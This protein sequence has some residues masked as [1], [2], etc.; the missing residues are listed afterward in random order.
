MEQENE[1]RELIKQLQS[2]L[3]SSEHKQAQFESQLTLINEKL[4]KCP[5]EADTAEPE[6]EIK[7]R[8]DTGDQIL[9]DSYKCIPEFSGN[10]GQ[11]RSWRN[12]VIRRMRMI[13]NF[14]NHPKYEA[15]LG[16][17]RAKITGPASDVLTN[18]K[19]AYNIDSIIKRLD[20]SYADQRPL[21]IVEAE[22]TS[23]KQSN[24][25][26][27]EFHDAINQAL[28]MVIT[29][30]TID[31]SDPHE[32]RALVSEAQQKAIRTFT[33]GLKSQT[34]RNILYNHKPATLAEAF[35]TAQ[36]AYYDNQY[37]Q[38][39][40]N[41]EN[42]RNP[43][44][45]QHQHNFPRKIFPNI[46]QQ[47]ISPKFNLNMNCNQP[48]QS[49]QHGGKPTQING[50]NPNRWK[51]SNVPAHGPQKRDYKNPQ[52]QHQGVQKINQLQEDGSD[53]DE[54]YEG[55]I[56]AEIPDDLISNVSHKT[57]NSNTASTFLFE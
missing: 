17:I 52:Q 12:Q 26:L 48:Q 8:I 31:Y 46:K 55:E 1:L 45:G 24:K 44:R 27:Q 38:L 19:T 20:S 36:T 33:L 50:E 56:C 2:S 9:L 40:Q 29:K 15:A 34:M 43:P 21:Y 5:I 7:A 47:E 25:T 10:K 32:Q 54:D 30:I 6:E 14:K 51:A 41:R 57:I 39:D 3:R 11:Y 16:I 13:E 42:Q 23:I 22:L 37:L 35:T 4:G 18:N 28:N 49:G 53:Q